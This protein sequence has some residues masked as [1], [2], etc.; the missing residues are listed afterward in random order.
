MD[1]SV[2]SKKP[3]GFGI[4]TCDNMEQAIARSSGSEMKNNK[5]AEAA[6]AC[7]RAL[8]DKTISSD[9]LTKTTNI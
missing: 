1:L 3:I 9:F 6:S 5:G 7:Y 8:C 4:I 2:S